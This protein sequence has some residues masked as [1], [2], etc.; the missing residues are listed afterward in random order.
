[1]WAQKTADRAATEEDRRLAE[2]RANRYAQQRFA[3]VKLLH[4][5]WTDEQ[6]R[7]HIYAQGARHRPWIDR[8]IELREAAQRLAERQAETAAMQGTID[9]LRRQGRKGAAAYSDALFAGWTPAEAAKIAAI[10]SGKAVR[11]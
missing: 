2:K 8:K 7:E 10:A 6:A 9:D 3:A 11:V 4:P 1:M 5:D